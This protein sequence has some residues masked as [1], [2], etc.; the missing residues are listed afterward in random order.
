MLLT[1]VVTILFMITSFHC[2]ETKALFSGVRVVRF[3]NI[4]TVAMRK[5]QQLHAAISLEFLRV[6]PGNRLKRQE[7]D[8]EGQWS[9]RINAQ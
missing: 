9:I 4:A 5:L 3:A 2:S 6:P 7:D 8:R 1:E